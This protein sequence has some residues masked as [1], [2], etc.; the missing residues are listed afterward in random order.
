MS[1][2]L[3]FRACLLVCN[4]LLFPLFLRR[5]SPPRLGA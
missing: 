1:R 5:L 3:C 4:V 2:A